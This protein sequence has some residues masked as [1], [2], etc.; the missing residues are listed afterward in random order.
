ME[1]QSVQSLPKTVSIWTRVA[2]KTRVAGS[3]GRTDRISA[4]HSSMGT[5]CAIRGQPSEPIALGWT[6][7]LGD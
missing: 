4:G 1:F 6:S 5:S 3:R 7:L 2:W